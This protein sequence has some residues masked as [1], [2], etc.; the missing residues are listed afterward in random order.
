MQSPS[1]SSSS[2]TDPSLRAVH[3]YV[4]DLSNGLARSISMSWTGHQFDGIWNTSVV[5]DNQ[6]EVFFGQGEGVSKQLPPSL[7]SSIS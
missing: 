6:L 5:F 1:S 7:I 3:L 2:S 4:Y